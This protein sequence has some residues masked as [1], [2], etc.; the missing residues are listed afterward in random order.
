[1]YRYRSDR[2]WH[3]GSACLPV[4]DRD[5]ACQIQLQGINTLWCSA[6][7]PHKNVS[8]FAIGTSGGV[9]VVGLRDLSS[10][11]FLA[12]HDWHGCD[13]GHDTLAI[14]FWTENT[15]LAGMRSGKVQLWDIRANG[16]NVRF[17]HSS[18]VRHV[19]AIDEHKILVAGVKDKVRR[20]LC[21]LLR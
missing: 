7:G 13:Q 3:P 2:N 12:Q 20:L 17:H 6:A 4:I 11:E 9:K 14:D 10:P 1:M 15:V 21:D 18:C 5:V 19:R 16:T 8:L